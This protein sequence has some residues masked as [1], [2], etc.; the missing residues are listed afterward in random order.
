MIVRP[1]STPN[2]P[3]KGES[4]GR[5]GYRT[6]TT[7]LKDRIEG[8]EFPAGTYLP[9]ERELQDVYQVSRTTVR[10]AL[11]SLVDTGWAEA[12]PG[13]GVVAAR[14]FRRATSGQVA[15]I[16]SDSH[17]S[18]LLHVR[19]HSGLQ[20]L[21]L[22]PVQLGE[23][24]GYAMEDALRKTMSEEFSAALIWSYE[25]FPDVNL[26]AQVNRRLPV[27]ALDHRIDGADCDLVTFDYEQAAYDAT[28]HLALQGC[29]R[30]GI[31][32]MLDMLEVTHYRLRGYLRAMFAHGL[33]PEPR[34]FIFVATSGH[35]HA[36]VSVLEHR[37]RSGD[38]PDGIFVMQD[39]FAE[40]TIAA[41]LRAGLN[42]PYDLRFTTLGA[43]FDI[44]VDGF[45]LTAVA[46]D[47][48]SFGAETIALLERRMENLQGP[49]LTR[50]ARHH[51][52]VRGLCGAPPEQ[53]TKGPHGE[54]NPLEE[55]AVA[56]PQVQFTSRWG[57]QR[58]T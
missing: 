54:M 39:S 28:A 56:S 34:D 43:D 48:E 49:P 16:D 18:K 26:V 20:A 50:L 12:L 52:V 57:V 33:Q 6:I 10:R 46:L 51:L 30:I 4:D 8:G 19:M 58:N 7:Y 40:D 47:W 21:G 41:A 11:A 42:P 35:N 38:R 1:S 31:V 29:R 25:G 2:V 9:T 3:V 37:L 24:A 55:L 14:G 23:K 53:W 36:D 15:V 27:V 5:T 22:E 44:S 17:V 32:G 13:R 45:G